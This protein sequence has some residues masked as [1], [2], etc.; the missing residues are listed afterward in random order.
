LIYSL[1]QKFYKHLFLNAFLFICLFALTA[2]EQQDN[3]VEN[4][5]II[6]A[7]PELPIQGNK[8][9]D[10]KVII[11]NKNYLFDVSDHSIEELEALLTRA[12]EVSQ[13]QSPDFEDLEI[14]MIIHG[15]DIDWFTQK[16]YAH[17][18]KLIDLAA[19]LDAY[20]II[21][22]KVCEKTMTARGVD[23]EDIPP[24][25]EPVP[26]APLEIEK[27]LNEGYINL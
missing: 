27:R 26:Y 23:R 18:Q 10:E 15:P 1:P 19:R 7:S 2:C 20:D 16:N 11:E 14:V 21:D 22:M 24:F 4:Q 17:N 12:E 9:N 3:A 5:T 25:I 13:S 8:P 6:S